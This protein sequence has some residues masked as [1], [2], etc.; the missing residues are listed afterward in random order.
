MNGHLIAT[1]KCPGVKSPT[2]KTLINISSKIP[3]I[4]LLPVLNL[5]TCHKKHNKIKRSHDFSHESV[6][7]TYLCDQKIPTFFNEIYHL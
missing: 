5:K 6:A 1:A 3:L 7:V 2:R 4:S